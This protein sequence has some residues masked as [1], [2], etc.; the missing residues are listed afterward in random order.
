GAVFHPGHI[1]RRRTRVVAAGPQFLIE[2]G[3]GSSSHQPLAQE[4]VLRLRS[5]HP[6]NTVRAA[7][8]RHL[9][10]PADQVLVCRED[11]TTPGRL[12]GSSS[13]HAGPNSCSTF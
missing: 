11:L 5:I 9:L 4:V 3:E 2:T 10:H 12:N 6:V 13:F 7:Q 1:A 8:L